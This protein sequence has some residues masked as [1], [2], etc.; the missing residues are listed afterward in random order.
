MLIGIDVGG[1]KVALAVADDTGLILARTQRPTAPS[2]QPRSDVDRLVAEARALMAGQGDAAG[3]LRAVGVSV[4]GPVDR[5]TGTVHSPPNLPSWDAV[6]VGDWLADALGAPVRVENDANAAALAE[7][8][9]GAGRGVQDM[10][11]LTMSTGIGGGLILGGR[12]YAGAVGTAGELGHIA[13]EPGGELCACGLRGCLEAYAGGAA[14]ARRLRAITPEGGR[15]FDLAGGRD[16]IT[17]R[18]V[19][20]AAHEGDGFALGEL[21][22]FNDYVARAIANV[23][24]MLSPQRIVLGTIARAAGE[25]LCLQP[26]RERVSRWVWAHQAPGLQIVAAELG[27]ELPYRAGV[28]VAMDAAAAAD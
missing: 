9:F 1:T 7:W 10:V 22:R 2:G 18:Q 19:V 14:W 16:G 5:A 12:L 27:D 13:V 21:E 24:M 25:A 8:R 6:P 20:Q 17:P 26:V 11:L 4:P 28:G 23:V 3:G 15:V